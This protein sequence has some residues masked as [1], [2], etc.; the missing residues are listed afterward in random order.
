MRRFILPLLIIFTLAANAI[1]LSRAYADS[2][3]AHLHSNVP[4]KSGDA[5]AQPEHDEDLVYHW[6]DPKYSAEE[7][8]QI[9]ISI[10]IIGSGW[11]LGYRKRK[12]EARA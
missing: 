1:P 12:R 11:L 9:I 5:S 10:A 2:A 4:S 7:R 8:L 6:E 3:D